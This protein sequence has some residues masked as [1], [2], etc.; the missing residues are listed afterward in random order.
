MKYRATVIYLLKKL[1]KMVVTVFVVTTIIFFLI[2]L[3]PSNPVQ[4]YI[5]E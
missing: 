1:F 5:V 3:M 2:R 4:Q